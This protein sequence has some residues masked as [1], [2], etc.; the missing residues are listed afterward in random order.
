MSGIKGKHVTIGMVA[1]VVAGIGGV[2]GFADEAGFQLDRPA[3]KSEVTRHAEQAQQ[4]VG[5]PLRYVLTIR[6]RRLLE[7]DLAL[8]KYKKAGMVPPTNLLTERELLQS[9]IVMIMRELDRQ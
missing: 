3:W 7:I 4:I 2:Y 8:A 5:I 6:K 9:E 1:L